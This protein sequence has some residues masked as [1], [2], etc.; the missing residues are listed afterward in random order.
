MKQRL[1]HQGIIYF[2][3]CLSGYGCTS[4]LAL[5]VPQK[6]SFAVYTLSRGAGVPQTSSDKLMQIENRFT[7]L[8][9]SGTNVEI[10]K[11]RIGIEGET[12]L[13]ATFL[14][15]G[16]AHQLLLEVQ[17]LT[18]GVELMNVVIESCNP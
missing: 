5:A 14:D 7:Q 1:I 18:Q 13:C 2:M 10:S 4:Q 12:K 17:Q 11:S 15:A 8:K 9:A 16:I 3:C 6:T